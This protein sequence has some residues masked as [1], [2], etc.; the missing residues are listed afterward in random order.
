MFEQKL[1]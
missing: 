1:F